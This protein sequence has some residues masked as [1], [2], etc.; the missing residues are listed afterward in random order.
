MSRKV[1]V[2]RSARPALLGDRD[3]TRRIASRVS[4][5]AFLLTLL[6]LSPLAY[7][8]TQARSIRGDPPGLMDIILV[9]IIVIAASAGAAFAAHVAMHMLGRE[10][11]SR[12]NR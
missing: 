8:L 1:R 4:I 7:A 9:G 5:A 6:I 2:D 3:H 12:R 11:R 10:A